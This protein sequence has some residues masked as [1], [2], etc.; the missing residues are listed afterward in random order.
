LE[1]RLPGAI[2][3]SL[4]ASA[5]EVLARLVEIEQETER[6]VEAERMEALI[7]VTCKGGPAASNGHYGSLCRQIEDVCVQQLKPLAPIQAVSL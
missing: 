1:N 5:D 7:T 3:V 4:S 6:R 2:S